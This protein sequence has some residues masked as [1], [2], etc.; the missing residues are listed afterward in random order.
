MHPV[1]R[2]FSCE[3]SERLHAEREFI[4]RQRAFF[5]EAALFQAIQIASQ[6][7]FGAVDDSQ[8][9][10]APALDC[11]LQKLMA[12]CGDEIVWFDHH[13]LVACGDEFFSL[14]HVF[15]D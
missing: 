7:V 4:Q 13:A 12:P 14:T 5:A 2:F 11:G 1:E 15:G 9:F 8:A 6:R 10:P 3:S